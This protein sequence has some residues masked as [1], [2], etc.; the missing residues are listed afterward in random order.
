VEGTRFRRGAL[1]SVPEV[2]SVDAREAGARL[3]GQHERR[4]QEKQKRRDER[5]ALIVKELKEH[6]VSARAVNTKRHEELYEN[7]K[8]RRDVLDRKRRDAEEMELANMGF[9]PR[10]N[11]P[12]DFEHLATLHMEHERRLRK[13][14][15][16]VAEDQE[17]AQRAVEVAADRGRRRSPPRGVSPS[18]EPIWQRSA[19]SPQRAVAV[20]HVGG[21]ATRSMS[22]EPSSPRRPELSTQ[23]DVLLTA[24]LSAI[25]QR[26]GDDQSISAA[27]LKRPELPLESSGALLKAASP[28]HAPRS[29]FEALKAALAIYKDAQACCEK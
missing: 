9:Q 8:I 5:D 1:R 21:N 27:D 14:E 26:C 13:Q 6:S 24:V 11:G 2:P 19:H 4:E 23:A 29:G 20:M 28:G 22:Q 12:V 10:R 17:K 15:A 18:R 25:Q 7:A 16:R 3:H